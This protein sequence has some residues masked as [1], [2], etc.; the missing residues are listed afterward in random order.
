V[1]FFIY[2]VYFTYLFFTVL[3]GLVY[4]T[5]KDLKKIKSMIDEDL[6]TAW[7]YSLVFIVLGFIQ[8]H[9]RFARSM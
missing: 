6:T 9:T 4:F 2:L 5:Y 7:H 1:D 8:E 3:G